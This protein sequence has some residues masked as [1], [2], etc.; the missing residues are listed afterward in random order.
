MA[1]REGVKAGEEVVVAGAFK[2]RNGAKVAVN[3]AVKTSPDLNPRPE[4]R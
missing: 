3:N 2:L 1:I 4:N